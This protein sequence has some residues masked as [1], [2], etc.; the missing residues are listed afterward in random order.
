MVVRYTGPDKVG[1]SNAVSA[2]SPPVR[3]VSRIELDAARAA[4]TYESTNAR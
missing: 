3:V 2:S 1:A 4:G